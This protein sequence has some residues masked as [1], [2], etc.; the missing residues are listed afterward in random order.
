MPARSQI[1][2]FL[3]TLTLLFGLKLAAPPVT[4]A[5]IA[6]LP[7]DVIIGIPII[8]PIF[9]DLIDGPWYNQS[10]CQFLGRVYDSPEQEIFG[11]RYTF[12][13][14]SWIFH[15]LNGV[16]FPIFYGEDALQDFLR[17][18]P[19]AQGPIPLEQYARLG[20]IGLGM[21]VIDQTLSHPP[22]SGVS[23]VKN[24]AGKFNFVQPAHAQLG[25]GYR[26]LTVVQ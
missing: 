8:G 26:S 20:P 11:E 23:Y 25:Y 1:L 15:S 14:V 5:Q 19:F 13:Q 3:L 22:A 9:Q 24:L 12:A 18:F 10:T 7:R 4:R 2:G 17:I 16:L 6:C 21:G